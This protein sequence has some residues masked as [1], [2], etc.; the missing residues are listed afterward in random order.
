MDV[1]AQLRHDPGLV[2][3]A[4]PL[5]RAAAVIGAFA[6]LFTWLFARPFL[7][8]GYLAESDLYK[9]FLPR[10]L[11]TFSV[12]SSYEFGG[13]LLAANSDQ[14]PFYPIDFLFRLLGSWNGYVISAFVIGAAGTYAYL[15]AL[16]RSRLASAIAGLAYAL[17]EAMMER[18]AHPNV[19]H[20]IALT[21]IILL[22]IDGVRGPHPR[23][24][25]VI[26][27]CATGCAFLIGHPQPAIYACV[28]AAL[29]ALTGGLAEYR[30][31]GTAP[32]V[33]WSRVVLMFALAA[34]LSAVRLLPQLD[35][36]AETSRQVQSFERFVDHANTP[37]Q[38]LSALFPLVEHEGREAPT[39]VGLA[40]LILAA[41]AASQIRHTWRI[42]FWLLIATLAFLLGAGDATPLARL[43]YGIP[44][45]DAFRIVGR[46]LFLAAFG[47]AVLAGIA[48]ARLERGDISRRA[49]GVSIAAIAV[50]VAAAGWTIASDPER[51]GVSDGGALIPQAI[52]GAVAACACIGF[53][54]RPRNAFCG[55]LLIAVLGVDAIRALPYSMHATGL[56]VPVIAQA[57]VTPSVHVARLKAG[58]DPLHQR[59]LSPAGTMADEIVPSGYGRLWGVPL[60]GGFG[61]L[62]P[63]R[64]SALTMMS[65]GGTVDPAILSDNPTLDLLAVKYVVMRSDYLANADTVDRHGITWAASSLGL[66]V[67]EPECGQ[68]HTRTSMFALPEDV[69]VRSIAIAMH[70]RCAEDIAQA[71]S[72][73]T[74]RVRGASGASYA[75]DLRAGIEIAERSLIDPVRRRRARHSIVTVFDPE[76]RP[77]TYYV[78]FDLPAAIIGARLEIEST[79]SA[80]L[81]IEHLTA[82]DEDGRS[83]PQRMPDL[84]MRDPER[85]QQ[86]PSFFTSKVSDRTEDEEVDGEQEY[87]AFEN[88]RARPR[89][90]LTQSV[91]PLS[92][93]EQ[94]LAAHYAQLPDGRRFDPATTALVDTDSLPRTTWSAGPAS[95]TITS[96]RDGFFSIDAI[97]PKGGFLVLSEN[98]Y[99]AWTARLDGAITPIHRTDV[100]LQG[101]VVPGGAHT[102]TFELVS[103]AFQAG[104]IISAATLVGLLLAACFWRGD[105]A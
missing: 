30:T 104:A 65:A 48:V 69:T 38:M 57:A 102:V 20:A 71:Q 44:L 72:V 75:H 58:L 89:A 6:L 60:T 103:R 5:R 36:M 96:A 14:S 25:I 42:G 19:L 84:L 95:A 16:T 79:S 70:L 51:F 97:T 26:G 105:T 64:Y 77:I 80:W 68:R 55:A 59:L 24:W 52:L 90:W 40:T 94:L 85:W 45:Y 82:I 7:E 87:L 99:P 41:L 12:W 78:R 98:W 39:Y 88:R 53:S 67:G 62:L 46:H 2:M 29:Y 10:F 81:E 76:A 83:L 3:R 61:Q 35:V 28:V 11:S 27:A 33:S 18:T 1:G 15:Y 4:H 31:G 8:Q 37:A 13:Y 73:G 34:A 56:E 23:R 54:L 91:I 22:S 49:M 17:S 101:V 43:A 47:A 92:L 100:S 9:S 74:L 66:A 93:D 63:A 21:P 86:L 32:W 50:I